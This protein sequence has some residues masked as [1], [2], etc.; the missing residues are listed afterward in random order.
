MRQE[1]KELW[2]MGA[3]DSDGEYWRWQYERRDVICLEKEGIESL[4]GNS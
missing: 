2:A 3:S 4:V 1:Y